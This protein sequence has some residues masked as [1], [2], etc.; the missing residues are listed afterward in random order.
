ME[1]QLYF[2]F[3]YNNEDKRQMIPLNHE[4]SRWDQQKKLLMVFSKKGGKDIKLLHHF[5]IINTMPFDAKK[6]IT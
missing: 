3:Q 5:A 2:L 1:L 4:M 6:A